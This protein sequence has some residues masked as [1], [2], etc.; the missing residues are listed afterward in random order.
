MNPSVAAAPALA[1]RDIHLPGAPSIWPPAPGWW[2]LAAVLLA[3]I[4][5][6]TLWLLRRRGVQ[7]ERRQLLAAVAELEAGLASERSPAQLARIGELLRRLALTHHPRRE[8]ASLSG[9][10]WLHVLDET[11]GGGAFANGAGRILADGPYRRQLPPDLDVAALAAL[12]RAWVDANGAPRATKPRA[13]APRGA[14]PAR[15]EARVA[16]VV[17]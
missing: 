8:V 11:G 6:F 9:G 17:P 7:R 15:N 13:A 2:V 14:H 3:L 5:A 10:A 12:V 16:R 1:L 4:A